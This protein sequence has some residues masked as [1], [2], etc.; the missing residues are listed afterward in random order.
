[1]TSPSENLPVLA[2]PAL[3]SADT[4]AKLQAVADAT[5]AAVKELV[6]DSP[7]QEQGAVEWQTSANAG[8]KD[9]EGVREAI[10]KPINGW[11]REFNARFKPITTTFS[12]ARKEA[13]RKISA[14]RAKLRAEEERK[15][16]ELE[17]ARRLKEEA[18][19]N[20]NAE[21]AEAAEALEAEAQEQVET[22]V[23]V[24]KTAGSSSGMSGSR[25]EWKQEI[26]DPDA[27][28]R[29]YCVPSDALLR[30]AVKRGARDIPGC[31]V[32]EKE[33]FSM[34]NWR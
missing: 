2:V 31:R 26:T 7:A 27:V 3:P 23:V 9:V 29:E 20:K 24:P 21:L 19:R 8:L 6:V 33:I 28:P 15:R 16:Q 11:L 32:F 22:V 34:R 1:M 30:D 12:E 18:E 13:E 17:A 5:L 25:M 10:S 14:H 4:L